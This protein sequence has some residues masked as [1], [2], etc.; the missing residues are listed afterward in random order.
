MCSFTF[1]SLSEASDNLRLEWIQVSSMHLCSIVYSTVD[2]N[3]YRFMIDIYLSSN[4]LMITVCTAAA[5]PVRPCPWPCRAQVTGRVRNDS[6]TESHYTVRIICRI[7]PRI[8]RRARAVHIAHPPQVGPAHLVAH[9][10]D[11][12]KRVDRH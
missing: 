6:E 10:R 2:S 1:D 8:A 12:Q 5:T 9:R 11:G 4:E 3:V 7:T